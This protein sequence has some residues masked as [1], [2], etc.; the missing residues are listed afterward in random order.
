MNTSL[1][2]QLLFI[3]ST[4]NAIT[5]LILLLVMPIFFE[6]S[7]SFVPQNWLNNLLDNIYRKNKDK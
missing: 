5:L 3:V 2:I 6:L 7:I 4:I 1:V